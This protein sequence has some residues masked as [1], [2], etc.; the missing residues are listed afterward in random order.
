MR[1]KNGRL[2]ALVA[3]IAVAAVVIGAALAYR[4][5][6]QVAE[7]D[8]A[9]LSGSPSPTTTP[10]ATPTPSTTPSGTP[11]TTPQPPPS[12]TPTNSGPVK[13]KVNLAKLPKGRSPQVTYL[14][15]RTVQGGPGQEV[16]VPG[17]GDIMDVARLSQSVLA[18]V[19]K[20]TDTEM[21]TID[22]MGK[23]L[24]TTP[25]VTG[26]VTT[27]DGLA[28][29][30]VATRR[31][32]QSA[33]LP[34]AVVYAEQES[35]QQI[36]V[37]DVWDAFPLGYVNGKV[38]FRAETA[39]GALAWNLYEWVPGASKATVIKSI[40]KPT[41]LSADGSVAAS[42]INLTDFS[43]C[44]NVVTVAGGKRLWR[45][46]EYQVVGFTRDGRTAIGAPFYRDGYA[47]GIASA[48]D[49]KTGALL[50]EWTGTFRQSIA[51]DDQHLLL[52]A[53][54]GPDSA[55]S[56][57]RCSTVT[58]ACEQATAPAKGNLRIGS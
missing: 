23:V 4:Q 14:S 33:A 53:D 12:K 55:A 39:E 5:G 42:L 47:D 15:G 44:T 36:T 13:S 7:A 8:A 49:A 46:C 1:N 37:P 31:S 57:I 2:A 34:G 29:A 18:V 22:S 9:P 6:P 50:H 58:G 38:Y 32:E 25:D 35:V 43:S 48:L 30:Y 45:T 56:I 41:A 17:T 52:L 10:T 3:S 40:P 51:E 27:E 28:A 24:R 26:I 16:K 54:D 19:S 21:L 11:V 20:G